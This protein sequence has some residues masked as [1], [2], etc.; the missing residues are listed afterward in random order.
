MSLPRPSLSVGIALLAAMAALAA[1][2]TTSD[3]AP[4]AKITATTSSPTSTASVPG[5]VG[6]VS[7][8]IDPAAG[9]EN[10]DHFVF[11]V[12]ENR[13]FDHY[14]GTFPGADGIPTDADGGFD[15]CAPDPDVGGACRVPYHDTGFYDLGGPHNQA[16]SE[17]DVNGGRMD[18]FV[19]S[20]RTL[21]GA[22][23]I[24]KPVQK[25]CRFSELGPG[26]TPDVMGYHTDQE[27]PNYWAY[28]EQY[29]LQ[30]RMFA[31]SDSWTLPAHLYLVSAW[32]ALC[33][34]RTDV[35]TCESEL[36]RPA[37]WSNDKEDAVPP[38]AWADITWL[39]DQGDIDWRYFVGRD[40][41]LVPPCPS[42][43]T[44]TQTNPLFNPL[45]GFQT[46]H[47]TD[48]LD[49]VAPHDEYFEA[50]AAGELPSVSWVV[51]AAAETEHPGAKLGNIATGQ[52]WVTRVVN[53]VMEGPPEQWARTAIFVTW[54][55]WGGF[56][57]H[58]KPIVI[59][60]YGY[61]IRVP[62]IVIS[63]W[64]DRDTPIDH[65]TLSFDAYLKLVEDRFLNGQRLDG[66]NQGWPDPRPTVRE[67][68]KRLGDLARSFDFAQEPIAP[69]VLAP[70]PGGRR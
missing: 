42:A 67:D 15:V 35:N 41:C 49:K 24:R 30:D 43:R 70:F 23:C 58:V 63:P 26:G 68:A 69:L 53:A 5:D 34:D 31:P 65:Q 45:P 22:G 14:F 66:E 1:A 52:A 47:A 48:Q 51:P 57:D 4:P 16:A 12:Q 50:A 33:S 10:I 28:A 11:I 6:D 32:S 40:S 3:A 17:M 36:D 44:R 18:G 54:D 8:Y 39:L 64:V 37:R 9:I 59:D 27:I 20:F 29:Q 19:N 7:S 60:P 62:G 21:G 61:G 2:C 46:V 13:S 38:Y 55:D 56:Y 25:K